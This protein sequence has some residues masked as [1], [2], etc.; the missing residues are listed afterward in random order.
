MA[1]DSEN[2]KKDIETLKATIDKLAE[3]VSS[4]S[5]SM[6]DDL[7]PRASGKADEVREDARSVGGEMCEKGRQSVE[8]IE[9]TVRD[10]PFQS[11][12]FAFGTGLLLAQFL[13]RR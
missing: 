5:A 12:M 1:N 3:D 9:N 10:R 7:K 6:A 13:H 8:A 11:L 2:L 4:L